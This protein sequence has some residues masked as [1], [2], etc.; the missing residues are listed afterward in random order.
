MYFVYI[1]YSDKFE[2]YYIG[3]SHKHL[4]RLKDHNR[5]K[6]KS[7]KAYAPWRIIHTEKYKS[8]S[9]AYIREMQIKGYKTGEAFKKLIN[10]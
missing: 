2:R 5:G 1:L 7:T 6:V 4:S 9:D 3:H 8:K 10:K